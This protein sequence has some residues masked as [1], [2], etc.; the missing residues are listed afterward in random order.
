MTQCRIYR[1]IK[2]YIQDAW[3]CGHINLVINNINAKQ[4]DLDAVPTSRKPAY[5][6]RAARVFF[7]YR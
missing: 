6:T 2:F 4:G 3:N 1:G 5:F 7:R